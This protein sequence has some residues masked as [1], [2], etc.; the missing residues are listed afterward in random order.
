[1]TDKK[2]LMNYLLYY[3]VLNMINEKEV[4]KSNG[5]FPLLLYRERRV[6]CHLHLKR[7]KN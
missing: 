2:S 6:L 5:S 7:K 3:E 1:M 4:G